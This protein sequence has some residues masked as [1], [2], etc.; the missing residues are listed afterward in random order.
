MNRISTRENYCSSENATLKQEIRNILCKDQRMVEL[1]A[2]IA[3]DKL[4]V[5][6]EGR[7]QLVTDH[8]HNYISEQINMVSKLS[9]ELDIIEVS[10]LEL[11]TQNSLLESELIRK[12]ELTKGLSFDLNLLQESA[13][14][15]KDQA[16]EITELR[17]VIK[18]LEQELAC[19]SLELDDVV[20]D[21]QQLEARILKCNGTVAALEEEL[22]KKF[23]EL[24]MVSMENAELKSQ[25]QYIEEISCTMEELAD[26]REVIGRLEEKLIELRTLI[27]ERDVCLQSLQNGFSKLSDEKASCDTELLILKEKLEM[28]QALAEEREAIATESRQVL[29]TYLIIIKLMCIH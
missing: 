26:K 9:N 8:V 21:R 23:D 16:A 28:A 29:R 13:S 1:M 19:K 17:K 7:L 15:A 5:T 6:I 10:A 12:E 4:F 14:V 25:L 2:N 20:S 18:S 3:A 24:N 22:R 11:S 27:D